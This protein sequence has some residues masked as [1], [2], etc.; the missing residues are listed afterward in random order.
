[1]VDWDALEAA[2]HD[3]TH[4]GMLSAGTSLYYCENCGAF[5]LTRHEGIAV[6]H[7][8]RGTLSTQERCANDVPDDNV[9]LKSKLDT[10]RQADYERLKDI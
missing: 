9:S 3:L 1:M 5:M 6:F 7:V 4:C 8:H 10:L 2:G